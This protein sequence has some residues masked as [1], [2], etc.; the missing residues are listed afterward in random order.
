MILQKAVDAQSEAARTQ[1]NQWF[2]NTLISRADNKSTGA[3]IVVQQR[4][5]MHDLTGY[6]LE[7]SDEWTVLS[8]PAIA[9]VSVA[10]EDVRGL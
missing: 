10:R 4:M 9:V 2:T 8:L 3:I 6:V 5:H 7:T 1:L